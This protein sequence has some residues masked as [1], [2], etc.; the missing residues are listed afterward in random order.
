MVV[1][2]AMYVCVHTLV[3]LTVLGRGRGWSDDHG[4]GWSQDPARVSIDYVHGPLGQA[5][6]RFHGNSSISDNFKATIH[7][8]YT[9]IHIYIIMRV[10]L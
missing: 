10:S 6:R 1:P 8:Q 7:I 2:L 5:V 9:Y 4:R 3:V